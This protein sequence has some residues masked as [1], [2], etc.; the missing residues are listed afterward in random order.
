[1]AT[2]KCL[3]TNILQNII[4]CVFGRRKKLTRVWNNS[5]TFRLTLHLSSEREKKKSKVNKDPTERTMLII[6]NEQAALH[7]IA[8]SIGTPSN[9]RFEYFSNFHEY[10]S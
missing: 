5:V 3:A 7:Y 9:E 4:F 6:C 10:E 8:K 2:S 1:M